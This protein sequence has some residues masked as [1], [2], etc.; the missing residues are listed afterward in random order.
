MGRIAAGKAFIRK[1][2]ADRNSVGEPMRRVQTPAL[3]QT[4]AEAPRSGGRGSQGRKGCSFLT[5]FRGW[6]VS[7]LKSA[8]QLDS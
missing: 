3:R 2:F 5:P 6:G 4:V 8:A 1:V 7:Q